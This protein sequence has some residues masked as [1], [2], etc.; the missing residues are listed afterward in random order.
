MR[1]I[2]LRCHCSASGSGRC[3]RSIF[4]PE[5]SL[6][7]SQEALFVGM[8][9]LQK[10]SAP[11][12]Q[13][14]P[15]DHTSGLPAIGGCCRPP[16]GQKDTLPARNEALL[17]MDWALPATDALS[18]HTAIEYKQS[19]MKVFPGV[20]LY[21]TPPYHLKTLKERHT[22]IQ[23]HQSSNFIADGQRSKLFN[24]NECANKTRITTTLSW[25]IKSNGD[26]GKRHISS[27]LSM[28]CPIFLV[29][30]LTSGLNT[31]NATQRHASLVSF[32]CLIL[33]THFNYQNHS[34]IQLSIGECPLMERSV[35]QGVI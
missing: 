10:L 7:C 1:D 27:L 23:N 11:T 19:K 12:Y 3:M 31:Y 4:S 34:L 5:S 14:S 32:T 6:F 17:A 29:F 13:I 15:E 9:I 20:C 35:N 30:K 24:F 22:W 28:K 8:S 33:F 26:P 18:H 16:A 21:C 2:K 25:M